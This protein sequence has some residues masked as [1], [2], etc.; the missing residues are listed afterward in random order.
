MAAVNVTHKVTINHRELGRELWEWDAEQQAEFL[1]GF[2]EAF[3]E[4][5]GVG[6][7]QIHYIADELRKA[8]ESLNAVR[9]LNELL[10]TY[11]ED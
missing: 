4:S 7:M 11:L 5:S 3:K 6:I 2:A 10:T 8:P 9:W 1:A